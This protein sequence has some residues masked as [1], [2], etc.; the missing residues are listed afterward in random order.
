MHAWL[1]F[2][3]CIVPCLVSSRLTSWWYAGV[4]ARCGA[5]PGR[6]DGDTQLARDPPILLLKTV[7]A[8][9]LPSWQKITCRATPW[10]L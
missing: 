10:R 4:V 2:I 1:Q 8:P 9:G 5:P 3:K 7:A 6:V